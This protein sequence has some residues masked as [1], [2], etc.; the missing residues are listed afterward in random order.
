MMMEG[1]REALEHVEGLARENE[2]TEVIEICGR[3]YA[4]KSLKRYDVPE[5]AEAIETHSLS[6]MVDYIGSCSQEFPEGRD[7]II[8]IMGPKRVRLMSSLDAERNRECLIEAGAV[9]SEFQ[10]GHWYDQEKF[11]IEIQANFQ[12]SPDLE[13]IM[14]VAGN[15]ERK[16]KQSYSDDG[17][18]QVATM[19]VG[20]AAKADVIV[21]NP[22]TLIPYRTFQEVAQPASKFV[23][24]IGDKDEPA[25]MIVEAEN[26]IWKNE[27]VANIK[28]YFADAIMEMP[29]EISRRITIIG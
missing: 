27:A 18:S 10:F 25:F 28:K 24:R 7:M 17:V 12:P 16:N 5:R 3:T 4:N 11:M 1:L 19:T 14:K 29:E 23:F 13:L 2:K 26:G 21:P 8:H 15:V 6:S 9:T 22:V 20:V